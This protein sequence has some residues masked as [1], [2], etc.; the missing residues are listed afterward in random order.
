M[1]NGGNLAMNIYEN[2]LIFEFVNCLSIIYILFD[3][4]FL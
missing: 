3:K 4:L 2:L 1:Q